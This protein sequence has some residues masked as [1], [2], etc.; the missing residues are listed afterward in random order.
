MLKICRHSQFFLCFLCFGRI[1]HFSCSHCHLQC[2][3]CHHWN[4]LRP[5]ILPEEEGLPAEASIHVLYLC[6]Y[7][8]CCSL[9]CTWL[10]VQYQETYINPGRM[11]TLLKMP[12]KCHCFICHSET[13]SPHVELRLKSSGNVLFSF[14][15]QPVCIF[16][17][18]F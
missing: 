6:R 11:E 12:R 17:S 9:N 4:N 2:W 5:L 10:I 14:T 7:K 15:Q 3:L 1:Q 8:G 16:S 18:Y 13:T